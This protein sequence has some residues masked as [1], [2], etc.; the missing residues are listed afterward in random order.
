MRVVWKYPLF[1]LKQLHDDQTTVLIPGLA[2]PLTIGLQDNSVCL[3]ARVDPETARVR[4]TFRLV[5]TG[6]KHPNEEEPWIYRGTVFDG[7][8]VWHVFEVATPIM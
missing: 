2:E 5:G 6:H 3:W 4:R 8:F 1:N 7:P